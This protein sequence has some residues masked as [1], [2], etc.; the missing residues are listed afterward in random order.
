[1]FLQ[2][3]TW[4]ILLNKHHYTTKISVYVKSKRLKNHQLVTEILETC[5]QVLFQYLQECQH[6]LK[7]IL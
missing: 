2:K 4:Y 3:L 6:I 5:H 1:M 7:L